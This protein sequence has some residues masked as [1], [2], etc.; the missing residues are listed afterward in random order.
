MP[1]DIFPQDTPAASPL[2]GH[3]PVLMELKNT[4]SGDVWLSVDAI[5]QADFEALEVSAP[6][7]KYGPLRSAPDYTWITRSPF[8]ESD[9]VVKTLEM[10]GQKFLYVAQP[11]QPKPLSGGM[12]V[13]LWVEKHQVSLF[14]AGRTLEILVNEAG[15][16]FIEQ[17]LGL[18]GAAPM[19]L[20]TGFRLRTLDLTQPLIVRFPTRCRIYYFLP[21]CRSFHGPIK[22]WPIKELP[23]E[24]HIQ[25]R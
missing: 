13:E 5:T 2:G 22:E 21:S 6:W 24:D 16:F 18:E 23:A 25:D 11:G 9:G 4:V 1:Q 3:S 10:S 20:P 15:E 14:L 7:I 8:E 19:V 17:M 12:G